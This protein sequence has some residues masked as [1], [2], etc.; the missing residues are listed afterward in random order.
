[1]DS[2]VDCEVEELEKKMEKCEREAQNIEKQKLV[3]SKNKS[4][5]KRMQVV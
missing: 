4:S 3:V 2:F 5:T 1:M